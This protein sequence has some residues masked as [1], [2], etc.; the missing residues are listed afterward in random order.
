MFPTLV[1]IRI[2]IDYLDFFDSNHA[3]LG[4]SGTWFFNFGFKSNLQNKDGNSK[5]LKTFYQINF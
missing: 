3:D 1:H 5:H 4:I 2:V